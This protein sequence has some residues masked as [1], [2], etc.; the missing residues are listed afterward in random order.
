MKVLMKEQ[1]M[2]ERWSLAQVREL[3][4]R[5]L[6]DGESVS[7]L[8]LTPR[9]LTVQHLVEQVHQI[10]MVAGLPNPSRRVKRE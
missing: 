5:L 9:W 1:W 4:N 8:T 6:T 2:I 7:E 10:E 3:I